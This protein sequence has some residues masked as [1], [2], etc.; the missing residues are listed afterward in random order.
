MKLQWNT[1]ISNAIA[2]L[3]AAVFVG[4]G[5]YLFNFGKTTTIV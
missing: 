2:V 3:V 1:I 5:T 4:A